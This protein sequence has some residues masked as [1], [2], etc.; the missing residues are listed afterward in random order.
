ME[1]TKEHIDKIAK[2]NPALAKEIEQ[3]KKLLENEKIVRK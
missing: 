2:V 1:L 3:K